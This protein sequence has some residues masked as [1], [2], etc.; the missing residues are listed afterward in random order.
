MEKALRQIDEQRHTARASATPDNYLAPDFTSAPTP[1]RDRRY[2][3]WLTVV[4]C[5]AGLSWYLASPGE[6]GAGSDHPPASAVAPTAAASPPSPPPTAPS[7]AAPPVTA[8][9]L[10]TPVGKAAITPPAWLVQAAHVWSAGLHQDAARLWLNG[11]R[12]LPPS[13]LALLVG[14]RQ[15]LAQ[16][17][18][19]HLKWAREIPLVVLPQ[20]AG[21]GTRWLVLALPPRVDVD[22]VQQRLAAERSAPVAWA[23]VA[24]WIAPLNAAA[25][26][27]DAEAQHA[28]P[29]P[30]VT[31]PTPAV[32]KPAAAHATPLADK[33]Q[34]PAPAQPPKAIPTPATT[35][36]PSPAPVPASPSPSMAG[37]GRPVEVPQVSRSGGPTEREGAR[38]A[39]ATR[40][41]DADFQLIEQLLARGEHG[42]AL[43][44]ALKLEQ[45]IG[46]NWRTRYLAGVALSGQNRWPEAVTALAEARQKNPSHARVA[47][48]LAVALQETNDHAGALEVLAAAIERH[49]DTPE[50]WLNQ[51]HSLQALGRRGDA[52]Q[53]YQRF[54]ALSATRADLQVQ[55]DWVQ[56]RLPKDS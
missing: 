44:N 53:A 24:Q 28:G 11:L 51:G 47:L 29:W 2:A 35:Q 50:L 16:A 43:D 25:L 3:V 27:T 5:V 55:R 1:P 15:T 14:E 41:I 54:L 6:T 49:P 38:P 39:A 17:Q 9:A 7:P 36:T 33:A 40:A 21:T 10:A 42:A 45:Q 37:A 32:S 22:Q 34:A 13:S 46:A 8:E 23:T 48:Y 12:T 52:T 30:A 20:G 19:L 26:P 18:A 31:A 56:N 4:A